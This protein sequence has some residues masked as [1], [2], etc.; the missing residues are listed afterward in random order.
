MWVMLAQTQRHEWY[1]RWLEGCFRADLAPE[2][3]VSPKLLQ[4]KNSYQNR[5]KKREKIKY[6]HFH[7]QGNTQTPHTLHTLVY[8]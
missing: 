7:A 4:V 8:P 1:W 5:M 3:S 6:I 2:S